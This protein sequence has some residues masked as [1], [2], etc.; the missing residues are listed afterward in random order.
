[1][2]YEIFTHRG[3]ATQTGAP[4]SC[5]TCDKAFSVKRSL[6]KHIQEHTNNAVNKVIKLKNTG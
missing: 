2:H 1:M 5:N 4:F 6:T 3:E